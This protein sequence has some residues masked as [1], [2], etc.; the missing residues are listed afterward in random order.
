MKEMHEPA[1][2][3]REKEIPLLMGV[4]SDRIEEAQKQMTEME[5][6]IGSVMVAFPVEDADKR[7]EEPTTGL[8]KSIQSIINRV[9]IL[10]ARMRNLCSAVEL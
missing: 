2:A 6:R 9:E 4:L 8:G 10:A 7:A 1:A 5:S 3:I